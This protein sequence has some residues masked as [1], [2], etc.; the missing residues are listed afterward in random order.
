MM[1]IIEDV[2]DLI[3]SIVV[4]IGIIFIILACTAFL[5]LPWLLLLER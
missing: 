5:W 1:K 3:K 4:F 2:V